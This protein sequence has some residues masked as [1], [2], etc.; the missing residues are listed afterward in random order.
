VHIGAGEAMR[1]IYAT[2]ELDEWIGLAKEMQEKR[3]WQ[4]IY[5]VTTPKNDEHVERSFPS[6]HC[7]NFISATRGEYLSL[8]GLDSVRPLDSATIAHYSHYEKIALKM[9]DRMDATAYSFNYSERLQ[10]YY[11]FLSYWINAIDL[12]RADYVVFSESPHALFQ[13]ILYAV[14]KESGI[15][16][17]RFTPTHIDGLTFL[18][19]AIDKTP[20]YLKEMISSKPKATPL[21]LAYL[22]KN[23]GEYGEALPY[24]MRDINQKS[25][26]FETLKR[27]QKNYNVLQQLKPLQLIKRVVV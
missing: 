4:P 15:R 19:Y 18:S 16:I 6:A 13:Y 10:L 5:W 1:V 27:L 17:L 23:R 12:L 2:S 26:F 14:C 7:Q 8:K 21:A 24:Y 9:M 22:A 25:S 3:G 20:N 11:D